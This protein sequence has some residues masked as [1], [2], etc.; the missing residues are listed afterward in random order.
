MTTFTINPLWIIPA[1]AT[2]A[3]V[4]ALFARRRAPGESMI[5]WLAKFGTALNGWVNTIRQTNAKA[6]VTLALYIG[7]FFVWAIA[8]LLKIGV[9]LTAFG[10]WLAFLAA[11]GGFSLQQFR[12]ERTTDYGFLER[13]NQ[14]KPSTVVQTD[15]ATVTGSPVKVEA[16]PG[17]EGAAKP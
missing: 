10:M 2:V 1:T 7:T 3:L 15:N 17:A 16:T 12:S 11:L 4:V 13:Q 8:T 5:D 6:V 14:G 9:D